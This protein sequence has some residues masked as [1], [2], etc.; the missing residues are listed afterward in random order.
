MDD[1]FRTVLGPD[2]EGRRL[3]RILRIALG[4]VPL[5]AIHRSLRKGSIRV[6][7][8]RKAPD[9]RCREGDILEGSLRFSPAPPS[10]PAPP[11]RLPLAEETAPLPAR[12]TP[13]LL[14]LETRDLIFLD[15]PLGMLVHDGRGSLEAI[16][17]SHL[18]EKIKDS[19]AF[20]PGP[21]HRLDRNT[22]GVVTFPGSIA[23]ARDFSAA[24][25]GGD[26]KKTYIAL[27][28]GLLSG[29]ARWRDQM[30]RDRVSRRSY[31][32]GQPMD[33]GDQIGEARTTVVPLLFNESAT[34][35]AVSLETGRTHQIRAQAAHHGHPLLGD[36]K[37]GGRG[38]DYPYYLHAWRLE[39]GRKLFDD[40]PEA[41]T[42]PLP[43][44]FLEMIKT[45]FAAEANTVYSTLEQLRT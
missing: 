17:K 45:I 15:K 11:S 2:D 22:S 16:V 30:R 40:L 8:L 24:L 10:P 41:V 29:P 21:L 43:E 20:S 27:F 31:V 13:P 5:S 9:Y 39:F 25:K 32:G 37:Y 38:G 35:A 7:G 44:Y 36:S 26:V 4:A 3:D 12:L 42:A 23:G 33:S 34:L 14:L 19:L 18:A 28:S 1:G 6:N